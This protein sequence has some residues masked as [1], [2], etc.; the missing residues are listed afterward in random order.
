MDQA[1]RW[2]RDGAPHGALVVARHQSAG[3]GRHDRPWVAE[4]GQSLLFT[5][6]LRPAIE[7]PRLGWVPLAAGLAVAETVE[8]V[9]VQARVKWPNDVLA[10]GRKL[11]GVLAEAV[12]QPGGAVV[13]LG[14]GLNVRQSALPPA[15]NA[16][17]VRL[18]TGDDH[19]PD[20]LLTPLLSRLAERLDEV[21]ADPDALHAAAS[22]RLA[23]RGEPVTVRDP[24]S[25]VAV[26]SGTVVGLAGDGALRL[27]TDAG[28]RSVYAGEV[29]LGS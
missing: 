22:A 11:A 24:A 27:A 9:G 14:V 13:L 4:P 25:R 21:E 16:T 26:A 8:G 2:A 23:G 1:R 19:R 7:P 6:V 29:T 18:E 5:L 15:L 10:G 20:A 3:R 12:H 17:S 28:E